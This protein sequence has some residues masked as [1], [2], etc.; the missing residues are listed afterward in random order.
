MQK[1]A[2]TFVEMA[3][4]ILLI[5]VFVAVAIPRMNFSFVS[6]QKAD[7]HARKITTD[8]YRARSMAI[9]NAA[10]N[11]DGFA[12]RM[13]GSPPYTGYKIV[14]LST[15]NTITNGTFSIDSSVTCTGGSEFNFGPLGNLITGSD[16]Q[17]I[18]SAEGKIFTTNIT[19][20]TGMVKCT[21]N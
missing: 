10:T 2:F 13:T 11:T 14:D 15:M 6:K 3:M 5:G 4:M 21:E 12:L 9:S 20:A 17:I 1:K 8:L 19:S 18:V 16:T 7:W